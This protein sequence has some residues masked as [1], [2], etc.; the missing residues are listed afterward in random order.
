MAIPINELKRNK[1][2]LLIR[3]DTPNI[4]HVGR[5]FGE[6]IVNDKIVSAWFDEIQNYPRPMVVVDDSWDFFP[7]DPPVG[8][9][10][11]RKHTKSRRGR[12]STHR[13]RRHH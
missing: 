4:K 8:G 12:R 9:R 10:R 11:S 7:Y 6:S 5:F 13:R 3:R 1:R 2:Y